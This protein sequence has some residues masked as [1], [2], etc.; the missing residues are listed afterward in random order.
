M[1]EQS[2][3]QLV[4]QGYDA[5]IAGDMEWLNEHLADSIVWHVP[6]NNVLS[7]D[8]RGKEEVLSF[9]AKSVQA[10]IP[11]FDVHDVVASDDHT[12]ALLNVRF[13]R[14]DIGQTFEGRAVQVFHIENGKALESWFMNE[15]QAA[16]DAF[17]EG[18][19][20]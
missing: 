6:G 4:R 13:T 5:F 3:A 11:S 2:D 9:F 18:V 20:V 15:D 10:A 1:A 14:Q 17:L 7:G 12:I 16:A 19:T 8:Y